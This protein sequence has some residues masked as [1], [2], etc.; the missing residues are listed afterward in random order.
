MKQK[1]L[2]FIFSFLFFLNSKAFY[3]EMSESPYLKGLSLEEMKDLVSSIEGNEDFSYE[4]KMFRYLP[5]QIRI[6]LENSSLEREQIYSLMKHHS[7][8]FYS[9]AFHR[10][11]PTES[12]DNYFEGK[13]QYIGFEL[14]CWPVRLNL[15]L[16]DDNI[17][18][19]GLFYR[20]GD[21]EDYYNT[22]G[23]DIFISKEGRYIEEADEYF[24]DLNVVLE[25]RYSLLA[26]PYIEIITPP[27]L[28]GDENSRVLNLNNVKKVM[29][30]IPQI[31]EDKINI[32]HENLKEEIQKNISQSHDLTIESWLESW[33]STEKIVRFDGLTKEERDF[34]AQKKRKDFS[35]N[36]WIF[37]PKGRGSTYCIIQSNV[38][39]FYDQFFTAP[40][41]IESMSAEGHYDG[42]TLYRLA[43]ETVKRL[44]YGDD[45]QVD[46]RHKVKGIFTYSLYQSFART[47]FAHAGQPMRKNSIEQLLKTAVSDLSRFGLTSSEKELFDVK[48]REFLEVDFK[49]PYFEE[50]FWPKLKN[51]YEKWASKKRYDNPYKQDQFEILI[52]NFLFEWFLGDGFQKRYVNEK[53]INFDVDSDF[54][55]DLDLPVEVGKPIPPL[56][57][58]GENYKR[59]AVVIETRNSNAPFNNYYFWNREPRCCEEVK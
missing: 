59:P 49:G 12:L 28:P 44:F 11:K 18:L 15:D 39:V 54:P 23:R 31:V 21:N 24:Y 1:I 9:Y 56:M 2:F 6:E 32:S 47:M 17:Y 46:H 27:L 35:E 10:H 51:V 41:L 29:M 37:S 22:Y 7:S 19:K 57:L 26:K 14:E 4:E 52:H 33:S 42:N 13:H 58:R 16:P 50:I 40:Y 25:S 36:G 5:R 55:E 43:W 45:F 48:V 30:S 8:S 3:L 34:L 53:K 38:S 20:G